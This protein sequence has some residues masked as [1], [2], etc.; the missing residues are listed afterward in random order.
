MLLFFGVHFQN[1]T[2]FKQAYFEVLDFIM[3]SIEERFNQDALSYLSKV[4]EFVLAAG[5]G[6]NNERSEKE[7]RQVFSY[8]QDD[9]D[10]EELKNQVPLLN[11]T[12]YEL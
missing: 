9:F 6:T 10:V 7:L 3:N 11:P 8:W 12:I 1:V 2:Y 5:N 4:K